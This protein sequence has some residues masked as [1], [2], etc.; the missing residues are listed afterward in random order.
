MKFNYLYFCCFYVNLSN[1]ISN[2]L[3]LK[4]WVK[5]RWIYFRDFFINILFWLSGLLN[6]VEN[7]DWQLF[8][9]W[10][11]LFLLWFSHISDGI[12]FNVDRTRKDFK[13]KFRRTLPIF[14]W[15]LI[16]V[17]TLLKIN[18]FISKNSEIDISS[19]YNQEKIDKNKIDLEVLVHISDN[20]KINFW[21]I[22]IC[23]KW[24]IICYWIYDQTSVKLFWSIWDW[25]LFKV[26]KEEYIKFCQKESQKVLFWYWIYL[27]EE[28]KKLVEERIKEI[29]DLLIPWI[30]TDTEFKQKDWTF[31]KMYS[32]KLFSE[33]SA[34]FFKFKK[35]KFKTYFVLN[36]NCVLLADSIIWKAWT[37]ILSS[38]WF[39][40]PWTYQNYLDMEFEKKNSIVVSKTIYKQKNI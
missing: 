4:N 13:R 14:L 30:P 28:Q 16:P 12:F 40:T 23:Y 20:W 24:E 11:Y 25:V 3:Y 37:D 36:T 6:P 18:N 9:L 2:I 15:A 27:D 1:F 29:D 10:I 34:K 31:W 39:I 17:K 26:P 21:H 22:D 32:Y 7:T 33:T 8:L 35:S 5:P 19:A 38:K